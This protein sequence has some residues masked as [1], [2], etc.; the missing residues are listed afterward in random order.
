MK[1]DPCWDLCQ[2][3]ETQVLENRPNLSGFDPKPTERNSLISVR[4]GS[5]LA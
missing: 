2:R 5:A 1:L 4:F 3:Q